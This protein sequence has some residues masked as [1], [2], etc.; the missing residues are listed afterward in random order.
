MVLQL[1]EYPVAAENLTEGLII[2]DTV[3]SIGSAYSK[4]EAFAA[5][6]ITSSFRSFS[7][8]IWM[9]CLSLIL[10]TSMLLKLRVMI[11]VKK[12]FIRDYSLFYSITHLVRI[13]PMPDAGFTRKVLF[14][15]AS[16]FSLVVVHCF[17]TLIKT[18]LVV[19]K[20][21][22][23]FNSYQDIIDRR[24]MPI[25][26]KGMGYDEFFKKHGISKARKNLWKYATQTFDS[27]DLY[28]QLD[29][30]VFLLGALS[31]VQQKAVIII[32][33]AL[34]PVIPSSGCPL[35]ARSPER[36]L[37]TLNMLSDRERMTPLLNT[38]SSTDEQMEAVFDFARKNQKVYTSFPEFLFHESTD[39]SETPFSQGLVLSSQTNPLLLK[40]IKFVVRRAV[41]TGLMIRELEVTQALDILG[42]YHLLGILLGSALNGRKNEVAE[43]K[44]ESI[45]KASVSFHPL[46]MVNYRNLSM[47]I[48][49]MLILASLTLIC[50]MCSSTKK[51]QSTNAYRNRRRKRRNPF[52]Y[53]P[54]MS[55]RLRQYPL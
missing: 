10:M 50:E 29:P 43:C 19:R 53:A 25:F 20:D 30:L 21:P 39:Q 22:V 13:H 38:T 9:T 42:D 27:S 37:R 49:G 41:E 26:I 3:L 15:S 55:T 11:A 7:Y 23:L 51:V 18:E 31:I 32:E 52:P 28:I 34:V 2:Y 40:S 44:S 16:I 5:A 36:M 35:R 33:E 12:R 48:V 46:G 6:Q 4:I 45:L 17:L 1:F 14:I 8:G 47:I 24:A 54:R